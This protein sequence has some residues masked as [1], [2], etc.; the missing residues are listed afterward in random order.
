MAFTL[1]LEPMRIPRPEQSLPDQPQQKLDDSKSEQT[2]HS[3]E[4]E[5]S[6]DGSKSTNQVITLK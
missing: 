3:D 4:D 6:S 5:K 1:C 2:Q